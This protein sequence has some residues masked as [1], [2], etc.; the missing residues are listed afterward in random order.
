MTTKLTLDQVL[1]GILWQAALLTINEPYRAA[2]L[3]LWRRFNIDV[4][5]RLKKPRATQ[6]IAR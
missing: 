4:K 2:A 6:V 5:K 1:G 3:D